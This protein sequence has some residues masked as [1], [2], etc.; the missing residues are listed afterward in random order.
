MHLSSA[1]LKVKFFSRS[2]RAFNKLCVVKTCGE[3]V[4]YSAFSFWEVSYI[5]Q[6][7]LG[8]SIFSTFLWKRRKFSKQLYFTGQVRCHRILQTTY[9]VN[10][11]NPNYFISLKYPGFQSSAAPLKPIILTKKLFKKGYSSI[12][13]ASFGTFKAKIGRFHSPQSIFECPWK[14]W[15]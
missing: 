13:N 10:I 8:N 7:H 5:S 14:L 11:M 6:K 3:S 12:N 9:R 15:V 2:P 1:I 4:W